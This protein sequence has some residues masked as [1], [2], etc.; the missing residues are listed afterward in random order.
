MPPKTNIQTAGDELAQMAKKLAQLEEENARLK[1]N[2]GSNKGIRAK[3]S[4]NEE[5]KGTVSLYHKRIRPIASLYQQEWDALF[6]EAG[7]PADNK[8]VVMVRACY[9]HPKVK[10]ATA[11]WEAKKAS[12]ASGGATTA[13][14][15]KAF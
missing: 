12:A 8:L 3:V 9:S 4:D 7:L 1:A 2:P 10:A 5:S 14:A 6:T 13:P 11:A 15:G